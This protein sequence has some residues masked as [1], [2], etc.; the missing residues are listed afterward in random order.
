LVHILWS[1][2][3]Y[4]VAIWYIL[5]LIVIWYIFTRST[6]KNLATLA[7]LWHHSPSF[8]LAAISV[9]LYIFQVLVGCLK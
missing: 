8:E 1:I 6:N 9:L 5:Y 4:I 2:G 7:K 3:I